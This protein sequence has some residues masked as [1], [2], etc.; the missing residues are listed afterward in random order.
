[1]GAAFYR[2]AELLRLRGEFADAEAAYRKVSRG[3]RE[4]QPGLAQLRLAQGQVGHA[5]AAICR[6]VDEAHDHGT[7]SKLLA[8]YVEIML[9]AGSQSSAF[10]SSARSP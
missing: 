3:E 7:R 6:V 8:A 9:A 1:V 10:I 5:Q 4:P 2:Q